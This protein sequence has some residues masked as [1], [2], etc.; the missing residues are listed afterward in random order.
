M[1]GFNVINFI[2]CNYLICNHDT[3]LEIISILELAA[4][5]VVADPD[6]F[7]NDPIV[8]DDKLLFTILYLLFVQVLAVGSVMVAVP[9][10]YHTA[11]VLS[12]VTAD[13]PDW[14]DIVVAN[15][16]STSN[17][18]F[19]VVVPIPILP[20]DEGLTIKLPVVEL[21]VRLFAFI[22]TVLAAHN[23]PSVL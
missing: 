20:V 19:G 18:L 12:S 3:P 9:V 10:K 21:K 11:A 5:E 17:S 15:A 2:K 7:V 16:P 23:V 6:K 8:R 13:E 4:I 14:V 22:V 1:T